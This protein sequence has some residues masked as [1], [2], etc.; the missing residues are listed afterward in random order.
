MVRIL[1]LEDKPTIKEGLMEYM[2]M[3]QY[4]DTPA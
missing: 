3:K 2:K 1:F 4:D